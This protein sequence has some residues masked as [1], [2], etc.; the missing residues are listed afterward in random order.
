VNEI[1]QRE[2]AVEAGPDVDL[3]HNGG[4]PVA[5]PT[6]GTDDLPDP[7]NAESESTTPAEGE[8]APEGDGGQ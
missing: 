2:E 6:E 8:A 7:A 1:E 5:E 3:H 4:D